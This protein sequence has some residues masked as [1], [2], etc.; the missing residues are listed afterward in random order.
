MAALRRAPFAALAALA[1]CQTIPADR[2]GVDRLRFEGVEAFDASALA[3]CLATRERPSVEITF[4]LSSEPDCGEPPFDAHRKRLHLWTWPWTEWPLFDQ[5]LWQKDLDRIRRWYRARGYPNARVVDTRIEPESAGQSDVVAPSSECRREGDDEGCRVRIRVIIDEGE[6]VIV[7]SVA[8]HLLGV[9]DAALEAR[10]RAALT[11]HEGRR[12][13]EHDYEAG[14]SAMAD[15]LAGAGHCHR[16]VEG[17]V[18]I[19]RGELSAE[20]EYR[21]TPGAVCE[22]GRITVTGY[23]DLPPDTIVRTSRLEVG[24]RYSPAALREAQRAI[25]ALGAFSVAEVTARIPDAGEDA[26]PVEIH[27]EPAQRNRFMAGGGVQSGLAVTPLDTE[28]QVAS[29]WDVHLLGRW[30]NRNFLGGMRRLA[31]EDRPRLI[32]NE[33]FPRTDTFEPRQN[34]GNLLTVE[35]EQPAFLEPRT[36]LL[37]TGVYDFGPDPFEGFVRHSIRAGLDLSRR[38]WD[39]RILV[40]A[41]IHTAAYE[42]PGRTSFDPARDQQDWLS[43]YWQQTFSLDLRDDPVRTRRGAW[44]GLWLQEAG[45]GLPADWN[46]V[47]LL[48]E[49][50]AFAPLPF[51]LVLAARFRV[52]V[53][54]IQKEPSDLVPNSVLRFGPTIHRFRGGGPVSNRGFLAQRLGDGEDGGTRLWEASLELRIPI[55]HD[56]WIAAFGDAGDVH[57]EPT[58][59]W[60]YPQVSVGAGLRYY[61]IVGPIRL[62]VG[63]RVPGLQV[64]G[65]PD[66]RFLS[67]CRDP[68]TGATVACD[69]ESYRGRI[70]G[71]PP[72]AIHLTI[73]NSF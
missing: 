41:G 40:T 23:D 1:A 58:F 71:G 2:Y 43:T 10:L 25:F 27:V 38:F 4:G 16:E 56:L 39:Q 48:P 11:V 73:G 49:V 7:R 63:F 15:L 53:M 46:Y 34:L 31:I 21:V 8:L 18:R 29:Q 57:R 32:F 64:L 6:P 42:L 65:G 60:N 9:T 30:E 12:F 69:A 24:A 14:K 20:I 35:F 72:G 28:G 51:G 55:T 62:D 70:F 54:W 68:V 47:R 50:R 5:T 59:R 33:E 17:E 19:H 61:T 67:Y 3:A 37:A 44:L 13:D 52:G 45:F 36:S 26:V 66:T 22:I